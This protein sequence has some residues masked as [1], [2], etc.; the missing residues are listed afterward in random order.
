MTELSNEAAK[1]V[2]II[3]SCENIDQLRSANKL[4]KL[5]WNKMQALYPDIEITSIVWIMYFDAQMTAS[6]ICLLKQFK[7]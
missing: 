5:W 6:Q 3:Q 1:I 7:K 2:S 4:H